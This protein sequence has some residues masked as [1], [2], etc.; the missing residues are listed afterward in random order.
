MSF[1]D[2]KEKK[3]TN[4]F[5]K[6]GYLLNPV[7]KRKSL[8]Y[9]SNLVKKAVSKYLKRKNVNLNLIHKYIPKK[10]INDFRVNIIREINKDN[11]LRFHYF[12]LAKNN[13]Y[14]LVGNELMMQKNINLS[15]Q[16]PEDET[17]ILPFHSDIWSGDSPYEINLWLPLV[18][19]YKTKSMYILEKS[20]LDF[21][22]AKIKKLKNKSSKDLYELSKK[23]LKWIDI[24]YQNYLLFDQSIP[25][26]NIVNSE[27][28]TRWSMN[29]RFKNLFTPYNDKRIGEFF[30]PITARAMTEIGINYKSPFK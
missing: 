4:E 22:Q 7:E 8:K 29:C 21:L 14:C 26:G 30:L 15:I 2:N 1:L 20:K 10:N 11:M 13:L 19:C 17:S 27:N 23:Y 9:I 16:L 18:N 5:L 12:N 28:E 25:H 6:K 24:K 3:I